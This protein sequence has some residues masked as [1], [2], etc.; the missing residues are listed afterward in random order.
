MV[1]GREL[2]WAVWVCLGERVG[3]RGGERGAA[4]AVDGA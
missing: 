3:E 1:W 4:A 2:A